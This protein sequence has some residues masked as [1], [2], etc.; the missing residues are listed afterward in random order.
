MPIRRFKK[1]LGKIRQ[2]GGGANEQT[3]QRQFRCTVP[4][5]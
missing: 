5:P 3:E 4:A 2:P 1:L